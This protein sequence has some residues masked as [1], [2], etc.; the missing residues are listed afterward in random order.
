MVGV[1]ADLVVDGVGVN[2]QWSKGDEFESRLRATWC[3]ARWGRG[4]SVF[5]YLRPRTELWVAE[6]FAALDAVPR[7]L[8]QL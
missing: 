3:A 4:L 8:P 5:S 1:G 6:R 2:H 7:R